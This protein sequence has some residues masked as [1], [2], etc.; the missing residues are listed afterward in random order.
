SFRQ[1]NLISRMQEDSRFAMNQLAKDVALA[2]FFG[3][4][5]PNEIGNIGAVPANAPYISYGTPML[6]ID[7]VVGTPAFDWTAQ[8]DDAVEGTDA[9]SVRRVEGQTTAA[10]D[11]VANAFYLETNG[12]TGN[13]IAGSDGPS[14]L[15]DPEF[16][17]YRPSIW[18]IRS[19][20]RNGDGV[21]SL[22]RRYWDVDSASVVTDCIAAG[23]E[24]LQVELGLDADGNLVPESYQSTAL[25]AANAN[26]VAF[27][28]IHLLSRAADPDRNYDNTRTYTLANSGAYT[29]ADSFYRRVYTTTVQTRNPTGFRALTFQPPPSN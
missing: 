14:G 27:V 29:P 2:G 15:T 5:V 12:Q 26:Q 25:T 24:D 21:P 10:A 18:Y 9:I 13:M 23:I 6:T 22:V 8:L 16:W 19:W 4:M 11:I 17:E 20:C 7:N 3:P 1:D 28:R